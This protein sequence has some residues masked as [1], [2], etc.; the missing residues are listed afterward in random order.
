[1]HSADE[2]QPGANSCP[3][4]A[5]FGFQF[6]LYHVV[7]TLS[8]SFLRSVSLAVIVYYSIAGFVTL[9]VTGREGSEG[10]ATTRVWEVGREI[11]DMGMCVWERGTQGREDVELGT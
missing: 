8:F 6:G 11:C 3:E 1:M 4:F 7:V 5:I 10:D 9:A 2:T